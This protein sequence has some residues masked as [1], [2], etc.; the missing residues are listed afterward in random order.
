MD[1][2][3]RFR[4]YVRCQRAKV[5]LVKSCSKRLANQT[6]PL[7]HIHFFH[8]IWPGF[9]ILQRHEESCTCV[10]CEIKVNYWIMTC[11]VVFTC[12]QTCWLMK[13]FQSPAWGFIAKKTKYLLYSEWKEMA[14]SKCWQNLRVKTIQ[15]EVPWEREWLAMCVACNSLLYDAST[16][17][18]HLAVSLPRDPFS[19]LKCKVKLIYIIFSLIASPDVG[20]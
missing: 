18:F 3:L 12:Q 13:S 11:N 15:H 19:V 6:H 8:L 10:Y 2:C 20:D 14:F 5:C 17:P 1:A 7:L 4:D 16:S 9:K